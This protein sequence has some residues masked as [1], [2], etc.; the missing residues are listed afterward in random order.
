[1]ELP[2]HIR[3][4]QQSDFKRSSIYLSSLAWLY[5]V[6]VDSTLRDTFKV[7]LGILRIHG[8]DEAGNTEHF[9]VEKKHAAKS[10]Q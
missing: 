9:E 2:E 3:L 4:A 7:K 5:G 10:T 8:V 1:M 6:R